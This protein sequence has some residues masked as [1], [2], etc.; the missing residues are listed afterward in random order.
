MV[1]ASISKIEANM[2][3]K[4]YKFQINLI[5]EIFPAFQNWHIDQLLRNC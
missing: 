3:A 2:N 1:L 4:I 5:A